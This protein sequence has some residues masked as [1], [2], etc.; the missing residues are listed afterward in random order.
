MPQVKRIPGRNE[1]G[2]ANYS[3]GRFHIK[4][5]IDHGPRNRICKYA[6]AAH[7]RY[8]ADC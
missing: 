2:R 1:N 3:P 6:I 4:L 8:G 5:L 7:I